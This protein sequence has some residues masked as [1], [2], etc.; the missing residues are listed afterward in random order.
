MLM[1]LDVCI[2]L[3]KIDRYAHRVGF[4]RSQTEGSR[5]LRTISTLDLNQACRFNLELESAKRYQLV[6]L[7]FVVKSQSQS[8]AQSDGHV[9]EVQHF[10]IEENLFLTR[11][12]LGYV[13]YR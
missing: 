5:L 4:P 10:P 13:L 6:V 8:V 7:V 12:V 1:L 11:L 9:T 3:P 2:I